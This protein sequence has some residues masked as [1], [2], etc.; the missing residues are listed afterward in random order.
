MRKYMY[1]LERVKDS[2]D[3]PKGCRIWACSP[4]SGWQIV[5]KMEV[6]Q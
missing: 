1:L 2:R 4:C 3:W 6:I 5:K